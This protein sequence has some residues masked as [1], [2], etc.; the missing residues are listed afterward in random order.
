MGYHKA[1]QY[2]QAEKAESAT[3]CLDEKLEI[4]TN[5]NNNLNRRSELI[6]KCRHHSPRP[7]D[8]KQTPHRSV[9]YNQPSHHLPDDRRERETAGSKDGNQG[10]QLYI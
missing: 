5:K 2:I 1:I 7:P 8:R 6:S 10:M 4:I 9:Q 3:Y